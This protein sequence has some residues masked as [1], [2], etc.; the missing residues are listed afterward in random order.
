MDSIA[1]SAAGLSRCGY[2]NTRILGQIRMFCAHKRAQ[3]R[4]HFRQ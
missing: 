1:S 3:F 4:R 2:C